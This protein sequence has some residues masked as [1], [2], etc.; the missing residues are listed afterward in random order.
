MPPWINKY[1]ILDLTAEKSFIR[2][3]VGRGYSVFIVS[4]VNPDTRLADKSFADYLTEGVLGAVDAVTRA[5]GVRTKP[6]ATALAAHCW[7]QRWPA[8]RQE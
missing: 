1:Y 2:W 5:T 8:C 4:W 3:A 6:S 7:R